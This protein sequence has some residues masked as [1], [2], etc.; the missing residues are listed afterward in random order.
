MAHF[1]TYL[2]IL[3]CMLLF[4]L[5]L[6]YPFLL[7]IF[8]CGVNDGASKLLLTG[9]LDPLFFFLVR[10]WGGGHIYEDIVRNNV[11]LDESLKDETHNLPFWL[12][13]KIVRR[14]GRED[15]RITSLFFLIRSDLRNKFFFLL[16]KSCLAHTW[17]CRDFSIK[18]RE[19][20]HTHTHI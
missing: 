12:I 11:S 19:G 6:H 17:F 5:M 2:H 15:E 14:K 7:F 18:D 20:L 1:S 4:P 8:C 10:G 9:L 3:S 13:S 16:K